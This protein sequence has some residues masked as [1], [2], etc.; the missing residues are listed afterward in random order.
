MEVVE[1]CEKQHTDDLA[2]AK[3]VAVR[4]IRRLPVFPEFVDMLVKSAVDGLVD[5]ARHKRNVAICNQERRYGGP[6]KVSVGSSKGVQQI[7][8]D[9]FTFA[10]DGRELGSIKG[11]EMEGLAEREKAT[12]S[13]Y[14]F[15]ARLLLGCRPF[16][17]DGKM[18]REVMT[19]A[20]LRK[21]FREARK[22]GKEKAA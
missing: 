17:P 11:E 5:E 12:G 20:Q 1:R 21:V 9:L 10:I 19:V 13:G 22:G 16:V 3:K 14:Y 15:R 2:E 4:K 18:A 8:H 6:A 7:E